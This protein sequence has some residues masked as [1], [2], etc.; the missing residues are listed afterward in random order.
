[1]GLLEQLVKLF[2]RTNS[3]NPKIVHGVDITF[4][5]PREKK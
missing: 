4:R 3:A 2:G 1:M 5:I